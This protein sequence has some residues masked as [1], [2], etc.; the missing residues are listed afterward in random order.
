MIR[1]HGIGDGPGSSS[2]LVSY[3]DKEVVLICDNLYILGFALVITLAES[4]RWMMHR[5]VELK[6]GLK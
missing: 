2:D 3:N 4:I 6:C 5:K 1:K